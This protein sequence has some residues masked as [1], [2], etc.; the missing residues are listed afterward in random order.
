MS[1]FLRAAVVAAQLLAVCLVTSAGAQP[2]ANDP[3]Q[4]VFSS[5]PAILILIDGDPVYRTIDGTDLQRIVNT[6]P[7]IVRNAAGIYYLRLG[8]RWMESYWL[9]GWWTRSGT[10]PEGASEAIRQAAND[11]SVDPLDGGVSEIAPGGV[12]TVYVYTTPAVL[13]VT[14]GPP[15]FVPLDGTPLRYLEN[16]RADVLEDPD[17]YLYVLTSGRWLRAPDA[18]GPWLYVPSDALPNAF[19]HIPD[20][21]PKAHVKGDGRR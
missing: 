10:A 11:R 13:V 3:P 2:A 9:T 14:D 7:L 16:T 17:G 15:R 19:A 6:Q 20:D 18:S 12:P 21:S 4:V 8:N 5:S 1:A